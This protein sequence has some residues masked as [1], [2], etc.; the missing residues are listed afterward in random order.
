MQEGQFLLTIPRA[1]LKGLATRVR[2][3][4]QED[5]SAP[6]IVESSA[7]GPGASAVA[8]D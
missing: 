6:W 3:E 2:F 1:S 8:P 4:V 7:I 5:A